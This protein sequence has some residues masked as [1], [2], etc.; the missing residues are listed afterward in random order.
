[1]QV[2]HATIATPGRVNE[3]YLAT[4]PDWAFVLDGA[5]APSGVDTG[6][7]HDVPWLV[8]RLG[9][10]LALRLAVPGG[11]A[12]DVLAN[13][14]RATCA[15]HADTCDL[16]NPS[17]P[18]ATAALLRLRGD[19]LEYLVLA[20][21]PIVLDV[22]G[23]TR[24]VVDDRLEHLPSYTVEAVRDQRNQPGGF[25]VAS[26]KPEAAH[27][28]VH[29]VVAAADV[30]RAVL[31]TDGASRYVE[32]FGLGNWAD[33]LDLVEHAGPAELLRRVRAAEAAE[34]PDERRRHRGKPQDDATA[35]FLRFSA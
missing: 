6:C 4:G 19:D 20:D 24:P 8:R 26:T 33:L 5:T 27:E 16:Q 10:E 18:S 25:W 15:A 1:M 35:V 7:A 11:T 34:T 28:A 31:L 21:S 30:R 12:A 2:N 22:A 13:A 14:I 3:D 29:G 32:R 9:G 23:E 17:S